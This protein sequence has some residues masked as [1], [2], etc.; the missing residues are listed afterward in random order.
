MVFPKRPEVRSHFYG[1]CEFAVVVVFFFLLAET[2]LL[3]SVIQL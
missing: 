2:M 3:G 1:I